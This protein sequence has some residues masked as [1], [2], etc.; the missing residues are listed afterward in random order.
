MGIFLPYQLH[1]GRLSKWAAGL[2]APFG[3]TYLGLG[4]EY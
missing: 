2:G 4:F 1:L 3:C